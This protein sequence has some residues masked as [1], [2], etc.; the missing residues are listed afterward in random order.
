MAS[1]YLSKTPSG[2]GN[3][4]TWTWSGWI[5]RSTL[6]SEQSFFGAYADTNNFVAAQFDSDD[7]LNITYK[8]IN[9]S[10]GS[11]STQTKRKITNRV[12]RDVSSWYHIV[13]K[14][15]AANTNCDIYVN[16]TEE[17]SFSVNEEPEN[18]D[19]AVNHTNIHYLGGFP[20]SATG[21][22]DTKLDGLMSHVH[23]CDG[24]AYNASNFGSTD[25]TTGEW[26]PNPAPSVTYGTN[27]Y[28]LLK[29]S[30]TVTDASGQGNNYTV[31]AGTLTNTLDCPD[32]NF[33]TWNASLAMNSTMVLTNGAT[34]GK[35]ATNYAAG[36]SNTWWSSLGMSSGKYYCEI[37]MSAATANQGEVLGVGYDLSKHQ[38]GSTV[39]A[40][41][42]GYISEGWAYFGAE[43]K[44]KSNNS[45]VL[46]GLATWTTND[47]IGIA[48]DMDNNKLY[49]SKN[50]TFV[51]SGDPTS[52]STG[53][54]AVSLTANK[55][56]FFGCSDAS[57]SNTN[58]FQANFGNGYFG[59]TAVSSAGTN[60]SGF[61]TFE[62]DV[63]TGYTALCTKG[64]NA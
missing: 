51:N 61:G 19:Y 21:I 33:A 30:G 16:G 63:P 12:F 38:Q 48:I 54:G 29:D 1:T 28:F 2:S 5:K 26:T 49:F 53:T 6:G 37:K 44:V 60:A 64:L 36:A 40:Y 23:L 45:D 20:T 14:F 41:H 35:T 25:S 22:A 13:I 24:Q 4:K 32:N 59:T 50:G 43:G 57:M 7:T 10:G 27:G 55:T 47:I 11:L 18:R 52:G 42:L 56:Y 17:T 58:T 15:D 3:R 46:T 34:T 8:H 31:A 39:N 62:Y 9:A